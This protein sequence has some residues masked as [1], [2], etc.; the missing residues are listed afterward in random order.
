MTGRSG[1]SK[2]S[3]EEGS[4]IPKVMASISI[5]TTLKYRRC[6]SSRTKRFS[7]S[8]EGFYS[9]TVSVDNYLL[10]CCFSTFFFTLSRRASTFLKR[11]W[12]SSEDSLKC[13]CI[14]C[15]IL[16]ISWLRKTSSCVGVC[17]RRAQANYSAISCYKF[18]VSISVDGWWSLFLAGCKSAKN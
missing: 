14:F 3:K 4:F 15:A 16:S 13:C 6:T 8:S 10:W 18:C 11:A 12:A 2:A 1:D 5:E 7:I 9:E 17:L